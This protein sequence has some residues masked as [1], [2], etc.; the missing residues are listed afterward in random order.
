MFS[1]K[2]DNPDTTQQY[3]KSLYFHLTIKLPEFIF[4]NPSRPKNST[5]HYQLWIY[6]ELYTAHSPLVERLKPIVNLKNVGDKSVRR[7][8]LSYL[9][10][11]HLIIYQVHCTYLRWKKKIKYF[12]F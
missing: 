8:A 9:K 6:Y 4:L 3:F 11:N 2:I 10:F 12:L 5:Q 7:T 1:N